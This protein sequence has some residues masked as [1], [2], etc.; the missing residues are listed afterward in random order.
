MQR[1]NSTS[2]E[3]VLDSLAI[4]MLVKVL[5]SIPSKRKKYVMWPQF[6]EK[7]KCGNMSLYSREFS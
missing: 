6:Q 5:S 1:H 7:P 4:Q 3:A 2:N